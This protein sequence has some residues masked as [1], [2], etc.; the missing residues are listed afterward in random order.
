MEFHIKAVDEVAAGSNQFGIARSRPS[1]AWQLSEKGGK[2]Q[3]ELLLE[4]RNKAMANCRE[5]PEK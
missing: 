2:Y 1:K 3:E 4:K 5:K